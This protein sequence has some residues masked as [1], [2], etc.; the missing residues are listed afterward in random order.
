MTTELQLPDA[1]TAH[2]VALDLH[3]RA[4][5]GRLEAEHGIVPATEKEAHALLDLGFDLA[6]NNSGS[7][8][9]SDYGNGPFAMAKKAFADYLKSENQSAAPGFDFQKESTQPIYGGQPTE[10]SLPEIPQ[11]LKEAAFEAAHQLVA[12][13]VVLGSAIVKRATQEQM[14]AEMMQKETAEVEA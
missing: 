8:L 12:D 3:K 1:E 4:F 13:P 6:N 5:L 9:N 2:Q 7:E 14:M 10:D 11:S